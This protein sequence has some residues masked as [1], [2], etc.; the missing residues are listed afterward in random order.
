M[1]LP[2][3]VLQCLHIPL[4]WDTRGPHTNALRSQ[5]LIERGREDGSGKGSQDP[6]S[7]HT[8]SHAGSVRTGHR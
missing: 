6:E 4:A 3:L 8:L 5:S 1:C 7:E 2:E